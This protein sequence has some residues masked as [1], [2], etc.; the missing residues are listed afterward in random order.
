MKE[1]VLKSLPKRIRKVRSLL[2]SVGHQIGSVHFVKRSD[3]LKR[4]MSYR[5]HVKSPSY[6]H[7][8]N[9]KKWQENR[10]KDSDNLQITVFDVNKIRYDKKGKMNGRG[11]WRSVPL[12]N[13][14]RI[15]V[16]G[17]IY[18]IRG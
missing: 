18:K 10:A 9:G 12:E 17:E 5:L 16:N 1:I 11:D 3:G 2:E 4:R 14:T 8:P 7:K 13:V 15:A 6:A